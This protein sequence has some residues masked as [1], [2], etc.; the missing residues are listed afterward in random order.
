[1]TTDHS[2]PQDLPVI[3]VSVVC[4]RFQEYLESTIQK[5]LILCDGLDINC[6]VNT[7]LE[8][9]PENPLQVNTILWHL[10]T[11]AVAHRSV[12]K[13][14]IHI[15]CIEQGTVRRLI[16]EDTFGGVDRQMVCA[17]VGHELSDQD[18][19]NTIQEVGFSTRINTDDGISGRGHG[20]NQV[21]ELCNRIGASQPDYTLLDE[22]LRIVI[23]NL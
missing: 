20:L 3:P 1:M 17:L 7:T 2:V 19:I 16:V 15:H 21:S 4:T 23:N 14:V 5:L 22:G 10:I 18:M 8:I 6:T 13:G 11:N 9:T 12:N